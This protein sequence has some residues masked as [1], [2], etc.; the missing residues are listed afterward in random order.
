METNYKV[1]RDIAELPKELQN[2]VFGMLKHEKMPIKDVAF[3]MP[4]LHSKNKITHHIFGVEL[5]QNPDLFRK[6]FKQAEEFYK[7]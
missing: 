3:T 7:L 2:K 4:D 5:N 1:T 6:L